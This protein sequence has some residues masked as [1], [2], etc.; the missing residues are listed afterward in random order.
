MSVSKDL[1]DRSRRRRKLAAGIILYTGS[2]LA[3]I[4]DLHSELMAPE[5]VGA[6]HGDLGSVCCRVRSDGEARVKSRQG[7]L[8]V[9]SDHYDRDAGAYELWTKA[10]CDS[11]MV[12]AYTPSVTVDR[13]A[14]LMSPQAA[15]AIKDLMGSS[16][17]RD[18]RCKKDAAEPAAGCGGEY[19]RSNYQR[20]SS[21]TP[22]D[23]RMPTVDKSQ[24]SHPRIDRIQMGGV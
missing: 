2:L 8:P 20:K 24:A 18:S 3:G 15:I 17:P 1:K 16:R 13:P 4:R 22:G 5:I 19:L 7:G 6:M 11:N 10:M 21:H 14:R 12:F 23:L 9:L